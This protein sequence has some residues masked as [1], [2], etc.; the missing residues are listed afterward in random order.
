M[1]MNAQ[2]VQARRWRRPEAC[3][4]LAPPLTVTCPEGDILS[5]SL[6]PSSEDV[7]RERDEAKSMLLVLLCIT[8]YSKVGASR[9]NVAG[10][11]LQGPV[12]SGCAALL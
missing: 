12:N 7:G 11:S 4:Q 5:F 2:W 9:I 1:P 10:V 6:V 8:G 3:P